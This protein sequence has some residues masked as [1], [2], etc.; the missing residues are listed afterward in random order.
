M[1]EVTA[2]F[3]TEARGDC[4]HLSVEDLEDNLTD[5]LEVLGDALGD[6]LRCCDEVRLG[7]PD[8]PFSELALN[9]AL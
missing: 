4:K 9:E 5:S 8:V 6:F 2:T 3:P 1:R 7:C